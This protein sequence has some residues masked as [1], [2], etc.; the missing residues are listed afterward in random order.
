MDK[1]F[2]DNCLEKGYSVTFKTEVEAD[3]RA[4]QHK[5]NSAYFLKSA[6]NLLGTDTPNVAVMLGFFAMEH[7]ANELIALKGYDIK[8]HECTAIF[9][10]RILEEKGLARKFND[11]MGL[12]KDY[13]YKLDLKSESKEEVK[14][15]INN[16]TQFILEV[17]KLISKV[18]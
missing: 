7:K 2:E 13:N 18:T 1:K 16:I 5:S 9:L 11:A 12:R 6:Q 15:F 3:K 17:D 4:E 14:E 10:S 8:A